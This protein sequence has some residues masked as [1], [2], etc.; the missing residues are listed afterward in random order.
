MHIPRLGV[1]LLSMNAAK[2][3]G[4]K[5]V[6]LLAFTQGTQV[7]PMIMGGGQE[8]GLRSGTEFVAGICGMSLAVSIATKMAVRES[9][10]LSSLRDHALKEIISRIPGVIVNGSRT[11]RLPNNV[12]LSFPGIDHEYLALLLDARGYA[13]AT[14]SAC[15]ER[16]AETS[17]V[18]EALGGNERPRSGLRVTLGRGTTR[19]QVNAFVRTLSELAESKIVSNSKRP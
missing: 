8:H 14:K 12:H 5:G 6:G 9:K 16:D 15:D 13:V 18:L 17:H 10:R 4:P 7:S 19:I 1:D 2:I 3:Y 11:E